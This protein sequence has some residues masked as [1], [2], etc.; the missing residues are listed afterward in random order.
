[1]RVLKKWGGYLECEGPLWLLSKGISSEEQVG[2]NETPTEKVVDKGE[3]GHGQQD[4]MIKG[5]KGC[6]L[7]EVV[8]I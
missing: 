1:M 2:S 3:P 7:T 5:R 4:L 6:H 8:L